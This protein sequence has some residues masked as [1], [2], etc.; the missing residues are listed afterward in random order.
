MVGEPTSQ[1]RRADVWRT[2][3][4]LTPRG[5]A[6]QQ[7]PTNGL[8]TMSSRAFLALVSA[9]LLW[10]TVHTPA[11]ESADPG[12]INARDR[13]GEWEEAQQKCESSLNSDGKSMLQLISSRGLPQE[14]VKRARA[15]ITENPYFG[16]DCAVYD[17]YEEYEAATSSED[18]DTTG[19]AMDQA[20][21]ADDAIKEL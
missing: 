1:R 6:P 7:R 18:V 12:S 20:A 8:R 3:R 21:E 15:K 9:S 17:S 11:V 2:S 13:A 4:T 5:A 19:A 14:D 16:S 10:L